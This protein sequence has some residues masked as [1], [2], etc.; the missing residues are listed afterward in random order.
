MTTINNIGGE[1]ADA[2]D[3][4]SVEDRIG[5]VVLDDIYTKFGHLHSP[6][7]IISSLEYT[8][9]DQANK[10]VANGYASLG[11]DGKIPDSQVPQIAISS[12]FVVAS[13][14]AQLA[15]TVQ[16]GDVAVRTDENKSYIALNADNNSLSDWQ[17]LLAPA[18]GGVVWG[19]IRTSGTGS[20]LTHTIG[21][22]A[23]AGTNSLKTILDN[24]QSNDLVAHEI[25]LGTSARAHEALKILLKGA[26]VGQKGIFADMGSTGTGN[27]F[28]VSGNAAY[29]GFLASG[30]GAFRG[31][32]AA[33]A[34][35]FTGFRAEASPGGSGAVGFE[36]V[37]M[38]SLPRGV[39]FKVNAVG[40]NIRDLQAF[41]ADFQS[42]NTGL[43]RIND[44]FELSSLRNATGGAFSDNYNLATFSRTLSSGGAGITSD[45]AVVA[46][47]NTIT[48]AIDCNTDVLKLS[49]DAG[50]NA[51]ALNITQGAVFNTNFQKVIDLAGKRLWLSDGANPNTNLTGVI[52]DKCLNGPG[53]Q[54]YFCQGGTSWSSALSVDGLGNVFMKQNGRIA[55]TSDGTPSGT[56]RGDFYVNSNDTAT[57]RSGPSAFVIFEADISF[58]VRVLSTIEAT[59][60]TSA[61]F[62][63][64]GGA[65][66]AK[67]LIV[68]GNTFLNTIKAGATQGGASAAVNE[69]WKTSGHATLPDNVMMIGV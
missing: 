49:Q 36:Y 51:P 69:V 34:G 56:L 58:G 48:P 25:D 52:G 38:A 11:A 59:L 31:Y 44:F 39:A 1:A 17:E 43:A 32:R 62:R 41:V 13:E 60:V 63:T 50:S 33:G 54:D 2:G 4:I 5:E 19:N 6:S 47:K 12:T 67:N 28:R 3:V 30:A 45:G 10:A 20:G 24:I 57:I 18:A 65:A 37:T 14:V 46:M 16:E 29:D 61:A 26:N 9:E 35:D 64:L 40:S 22:N 55:Y 7:E 42:Q 27:A 21:A 53:G 8:P 23:A 15:L 66:I 68:G